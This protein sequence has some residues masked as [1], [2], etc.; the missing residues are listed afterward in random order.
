MSTPGIEILSEHDE[1]MV[2]G[3]GLALGRGFA[4]IQWDAQ[5]VSLCCPL[6]LEVF[7]KSPGP[8]VSRRA[9]RKL[10]VAANGAERR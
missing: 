6:C 1:C 4:L 10:C 3:K 8:Y 2:C 9:S 7:Q 5:W